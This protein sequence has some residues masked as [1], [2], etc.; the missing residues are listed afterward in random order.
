[1]REILAR[2]F[3]WNNSKLIV[4]D[5]VLAEKILKIFFYFSIGLYRNARPKSLGKSERTCSGISLASQHLI[6]M[7]TTA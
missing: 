7:F 2:F 6:P 3:R 5:S 1:M 4:T